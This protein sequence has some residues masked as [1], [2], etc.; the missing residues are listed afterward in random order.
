MPYQLSSALLCHV[1]SRHRARAHPFSTFWGEKLH[2]AINSRAGSISKNQGVD[3]LTKKVRKDSVILIHCQESETEWIQPYSIRPLKAAATEPF[4]D[5]EM[6]HERK[7]SIFDTAHHL[8]VQKFQEAK[9]K[10]SLKRVLAIDDETDDDQGDHVDVDDLLEDV[11]KDGVGEE[12]GNSNTE[13][14]PAQ[15]Q[16][17]NDDNAT[18][19]GTTDPIPIAAEPKPVNSASAL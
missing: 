1:V 11:E 6:D 5:L 19:K 4:P 18:E 3:S 7:S 9:R 14:S 15:A 17:G 10:V 2:Y 8:A 12:K 16:T 13:E